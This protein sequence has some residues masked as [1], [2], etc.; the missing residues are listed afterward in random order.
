MFTLD[1]VSQPR[2]LTEIV[3]LRTAVLQPS[4]PTRPSPTA[5]EIVLIFVKIFKDFLQWSRTTSHSE[6]VIQNTN[7]YFREKSFNSL[8]KNLYNFRNVKFSVYSFSRS[9]EK[10]TRSWTIPKFPINILLVIYVYFTINFCQSNWLEFTTQLFKV[11]VYWSRRVHREKLRGEEGC[12]VRPV[13]CS[14]LCRGVN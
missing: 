4:S 11:E 1:W 8:K 13:R 2:G 6:N 5:R 14:G 9:E 12:V 7:I 10:P 3:L